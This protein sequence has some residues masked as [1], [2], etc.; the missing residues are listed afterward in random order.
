MAKNLGAYV[1]LYEERVDA[2]ITKNQKNLDKWT[3]RHE[4]YIKLYPKVLKTAEDLGIKEM[5]QKLYPKG[6]GRPGVFST[7]IASFYSH[8]E[9]V[10]PIKALNKIADSP[11]RVEKAAKYLETT[12]GWKGK[13]EDYL[14][15]IGSSIVSTMAVA[16]S[17]GANSLDEL[18]D[19][20][21]SEYASYEDIAEFGSHEIDGPSGVK[22]REVTYLALKEK[23]DN[24]ELYKKVEPVEEG[25]ESVA[26]NPDVETETD[27]EETEAP[28]EDVPAETG[29]SSEPIALPEENI[30]T[31]DVTESET[32]AEEN[33]EEVKSETPDVESEAET[34]VV[35]DTT[36]ITNTI[37]DTAAAEALSA[38]PAPDAPVAESPINAEP[39]KKGRFKDFLNKAK[40]K[41]QVLSETG[42]LTQLFKKSEDNSTIE[43]DSNAINNTGGQ[44]TTG[45][46]TDETTDI[47]IDSSS[48]NDASSAVAGNNTENVD[49]SITNESS[50][51]VNTDLS[52]LSDANTES[53]ETN[54]V[55]NFSA[56]NVAKLGPTAEPASN[57]SIKNLGDTIVSNTAAPS[58]VPAEMTKS[59][60]LTP[61]KKS[62]PV[63]TPNTPSVDTSG[64]SQSNAGLAAAVAGMTK[65]LK[66]IKSLL[67]GPLDVKIKNR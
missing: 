29:V 54:K 51:T 66:S 6:G 1:A 24:G 43:G 52:A 55:S 26:I 40:D 64:A 13:G 39:K 38:T 10:L 15:K 28:T 60:G 7:D 25:G 20:V 50:T 42:D 41:L 58:Q 22:T 4:E 19:D 12:K 3:S 5:F 30:E 33:A 9:D 27:E 57:E 63:S 11:H 32:P 17:S 31:E 21:F 45:I 2:T 35:S 56:P 61:G 65:E 37:N 67:Q 59:G 62:A 36:N 34:S 23:H 53:T 46:S 14:S 8:G 16:A 49:A 18:M 48:I 47:A 44:D